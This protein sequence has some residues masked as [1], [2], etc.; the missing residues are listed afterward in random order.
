MKKRVEK[1]QKCSNIVHFIIKHIH[2]IPPL[3]RPNLKGNKFLI[4]LF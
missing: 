3:L 4:R 2:E 1:L